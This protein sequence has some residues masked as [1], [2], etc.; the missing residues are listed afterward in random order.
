VA[1]VAADSQG[2]VEAVLDM[3]NLGK[4]EVQV[5]VVQCE[6]GR[7]VVHLVSAGNEAPP[8]DQKCKRRLLGAFL[9][10]H[11]TKVTIDLANGTVDATG[12]SAMRTRLLLIGGGVAA[13]GAGIAAGSGSSSTSTSSQPASSTPST[14][15]PTPTP[16]PSPTPTPTP[17]PTPAINPVGTFPS[18]TSVVSGQIHEAFVALAKSLDLVFASFSGLQGAAT[19]TVKVTGPSGSNWVAVTGSVDTDSGK[20]SLTGSGTVAGYSNV[21]VKFEGTVTKD[22]TLNGTYTMGAGGELPQGIPIVYSVQGQK[23]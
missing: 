4:V 9:F 14:P 17:E 12:G 21:S 13:V 23:R 1:T 19:T 7:N 10:K 3:A 16:T 5:Y 18:A 8:E 15:T 2:T 6:D 22:G 20:F 11:G